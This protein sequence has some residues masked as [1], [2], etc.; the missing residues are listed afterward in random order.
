MSD[1][2]FEALHFISLTRFLSK[3][4]K[5]DFSTIIETCFYFVTLYNEV[6]F[7]QNFDPSE[8]WRKYTF[9]AS[10]NPFQKSVLY[11]LDV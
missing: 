8:F 1:A 2:K 9:C 4:R 3:L 5:Y 7:L 11:C 6:L 10:L